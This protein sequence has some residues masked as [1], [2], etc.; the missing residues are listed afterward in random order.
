IPTGGSLR[1]TDIGPEGEMLALPSTYNES[2]R[3]TSRIIARCNTY[4]PRITHSEYSHGFREPLLPLADA[5]IV[6]HGND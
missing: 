2:F 4:R 6:H 3:A 1:F 5:P